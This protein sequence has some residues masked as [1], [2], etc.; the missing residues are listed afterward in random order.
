LS[1]FLLQSLAQ[2]S[3]LTS[4]EGRARLVAQ[5]QPYLSRLREGPLRSAVVEDLARLARLNREDV[6]R[7][8]QAP[9]PPRP[10]QPAP[11][12]DA[13]SPPE[14]APL[15]RRGIKLLLNRP[16]MAERVEHIGHLLDSP[17]A[18][19]DQLVAVLDF[20]VADP[21]SRVS[22]L[23]EAWRG[24]PG[25][26][27]VAALAAEPMAELDDAGIELEFRDVMAQIRQRTLR[28]H[29][30]KLLQKAATGPLTA[31]EQ[32]ELEQVSQQLSKRRLVEP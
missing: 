22:W 9:A 16:D 5:V 14:I 24:T 21:T 15:V 2:R 6:E 4:R 13:P 17:L 29:M 20:F 19:I 12:E 23:I 8:L 3:D 26:A 27:L 10:A 1:D 25:G 32:E 30:Q 11:A 31:A 7:S 28:A 18:G